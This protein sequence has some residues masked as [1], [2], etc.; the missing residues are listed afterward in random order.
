[1]DLTTL[2]NNLKPL[3]SIRSD[4]ILV[5]LSVRGYLEEILNVLTT[6]ESRDTSRKL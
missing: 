6:V 5:F 2:E 4:I 3:Q 1:M